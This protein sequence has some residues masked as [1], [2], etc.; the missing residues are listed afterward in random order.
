[1][2]N[3]AG[4]V[5]SNSK[6][7]RAIVTNNAVDVSV[8]DAPHDAVP[9]EP[10]EEVLKLIKSLLSLLEMYL[11]L[12]FLQ[13]CIWTA[14]ALQTAAIRNNSSAQA[15]N[16]FEAD[17][18]GEK[19]SSLLIMLLI[20]AANLKENVDRTGEA[21]E[22]KPKSVDK[23]RDQNKK[24]GDWN[25]V[26]TRKSSTQKQ[27]S[28]KQQNKNGRRIELNVGS[29]SNAF[30]ALAN[31][32]EHAVD[33]TVSEVKEKFNQLVAMHNKDRDGL[34][35]PELAENLRVRQSNSMNNL[36]TELTNNQAHISNLPTLYYSNPQVEQIIKN[37]QKEM[38]QP[39]L[40]KQP[41]VTLNTSVFDVL[42]NSIKSYGEFEG[43]PGQQIVSTGNN[44]EL[45]QAKVTE[46]VI[47][48]KPWKD[49]REYD[50]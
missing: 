43:E 12:P 26:T 44:N 28:S 9:V 18:P 5:Q 2:A 27:S 6:K 20:S 17:L 25:L 31:A 11:T 19:K 16:E 23:G 38:M 15:G 41:L 1:M 39:T 8:S 3:T 7:N 33:A 48:S 35:N 50:D 36:G 34:G 47:N 10:L 37:T 30:D 42:L 49:Q 46:M 13:E 21:S 40:T 45:I 32:G 14:G 24:G 29:N 4:F 22:P